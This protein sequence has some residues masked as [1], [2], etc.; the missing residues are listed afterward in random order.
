MLIRALI[1]VGVLWPHAAQASEF[2]A[3]DL[4]ITSPWMYATPEGAKVRGG[5]MVLTNTGNEDDRLIGAAADISGSVEIHEQGMLN[6]V[7]MWRPS[8]HGIAIMAGSSVTLRLFTH[9]HLMFMDLKQPLVAGQKIKG[10]LR[11][12]KAGEVEIEYEVVRL[13]AKGSAPALR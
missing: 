3:G 10:L 4:V 9:H 12:Q 7:L 6:G 2:K 13:G 11:F 5:Y 1:L 8:S